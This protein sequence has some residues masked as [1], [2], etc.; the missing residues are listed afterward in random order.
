MSKMP[1]PEQQAQLAEIDKQIAE[2]RKQIADELAKIEYVEPADSAAPVAFPSRPSTSGST[3]PLRRAPSSRATRPGSSSARRI[4]PRFSGER[5]STRTANGVSQHF[6]T[7][8]NPP[9]HV[10]EGD[11]LFAYVYL[12]PNNPPKTIMLQWNDGTWEHRAFWGED[13]IRVRQRRAKRPIT[14]TWARC[15]KPASG[16]GWKSRPRKS[17]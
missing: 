16:C 6:F 12:D 10:G 17:A 1:P 15:P 3:T 2:A 7:D 9:L 4:S 13:L 5:A 14:C 11:K 8:A